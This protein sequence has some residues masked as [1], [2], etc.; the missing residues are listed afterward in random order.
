MGTFISK[1]RLS[2]VLYLDL[3]GLSSCAA[4]GTEQTCPV[5]LN[6]GASCN[7]RTSRKF[8]RFVCKVELCSGRLHDNI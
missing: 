8:T 3:L 2:C 6:S 1:A 5:M 7:D 4:C